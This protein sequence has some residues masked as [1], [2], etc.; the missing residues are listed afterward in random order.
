MFLAAIC[1][2]IMA[3]LVRFVSEEMHPFQVAF[4]RNVIGICL[5]LPLLLQTG[6]EPLK[7]QN[8]GY[9]ALR[10]VF[11]AVAI[12]TYFLSLTMLP[13]SEV[14]ALTFTVPVFVSLMAVLILRE[15]LGPR[16]IASLVAG[17]FGAMIV[18]R[19]GIQIIDI[20]AIYALT[21]ALTW[22][23]AIIII[24]HLSQNNSSVTITIYG[25][26]FLAIFTLP[27]ALLVWKWPTWHQF[28]W[29][30][31]M[32]IIGT[33]GQLLFVQSLRLCD[34]TL[35]MPFDFTKLIW[36]SLIGFY[37]F[38]EAPTVWT[39]LGG[40]VIFVSATY[41]TFREG[42]EITPVTAS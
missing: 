36:A 39:I 8:I 19:P 25:L 16:R 27:P 1:M 32:A 2:T 30:V 38:S 26:F 31:G 40:A 21:S 11:N 37:V 20:G 29:L 24:K 9:M 5:F 4:C 3:A 42:R 35:V 33:A 34:A 6:M 15:R 13:L 23:I 17:F 14:S 28:L 22:A 7:T 41:L 12:L 10:G 18:L